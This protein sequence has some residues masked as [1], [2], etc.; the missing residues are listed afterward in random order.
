MRLYLP[1]HLANNGASGLADC[2]HAECGEDEGKQSTEEQSD[3]HLR[4]GKRKLENER[5][6]IAC[7]VHF[8]FLYVRAKQNERC[9]A[10]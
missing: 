3:N 4:V 1:T 2:V 5:L 6:A 7:N 9:Q 8:E 10:G